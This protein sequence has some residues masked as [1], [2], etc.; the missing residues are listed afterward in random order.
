MFKRTLIFASVISVFTSA[1]IINL[2]ILD[3]LSIQELKQSLGKILSVI[4]VSTVA[5]L[6]ILVLVRLRT[7]RS[8]DRNSR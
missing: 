7:K 6:L 4:G 8:S 2:A 1:V 5:I 3:L